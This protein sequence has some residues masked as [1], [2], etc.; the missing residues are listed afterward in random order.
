MLIIPA[1]DLK[2]GQ[3]VRYTQG[4]LDKKVYSDNPVL[5]AKD[6]QRQGA[7]FLHLVDL[8][9]AMSGEQK[10]LILIKKIIK[11][12]RIPVEVG[13]G[14][15]DMAAIQKII[16][17]GAKRAIIG[18]K[19]IEEISF[20]EK[21][22]KK[23]GNKIALS[24]DASGKMLAL[25]GWKKQAQIEFEPFLRKLESLHLGTIIYTDI[26]RDGTLSGLNISI[27]K[28][29]LRLTP[30]DVIVSGGVSSLDDKRRLS[31]LKFSNLKGLIIGKALYEKR[32][33]LKEAV[34][35]QKRGSTIVT[36]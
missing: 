9:G 31:K 13:G 1:I 29:M 30:M 19:A 6:W 7:S 25:Y 26:T 3:V 33:S 20:L 12:L 16:E 2:D 34:A 18:T 21:S 32:F 28:K 35:A 10:N 14:I 17:A 15:R 22:V 23:F 27:I 8:D 11:A 4:R 5:V 36:A 24:L